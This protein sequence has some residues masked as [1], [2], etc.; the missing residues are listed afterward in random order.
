YVGAHRAELDGKSRR[1]TL[2]AVGFRASSSLVVP[3][4]AEKV[5]DIIA[6]L[7]GLQLTGCIKTTETLDR[8]ALRHQPTDIILQLGLS[9]RTKDEFYYDLDHD[10]IADT[11]T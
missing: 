6:Q 4:N 9:V 7:R 5:A 2:G 3:T 11:A 8:D 1:L 10:G